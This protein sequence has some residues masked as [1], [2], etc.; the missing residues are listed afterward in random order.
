[1]KRILILSILMLSNSGFSQEV[2]IEKLEQSKSH[3]QAQIKSLND[4]ISVIN[5]LISELKM[6][7]LQNKFNHSTLTTKVRKGANLKDSPTPL[8]NIV[9]DL[10][11]NE[12]V[13]IK[14]L[15]GDYLGVCAKNKCGYLSIMWVERNEEIDQF[16]LAKEAEQRKLEELQAEQKLKE[17]KAEWEKIEKKYIQK[18]GKATYDK[19]KKGYYWIGMTEE[20][21][22]ISLGMPNDVNRT[23]GIWGVH[24]Q[25]I[26][27]NVYLY[28][29]NGKL[30]SYQ[31]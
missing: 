22:T 28:F 3:I 7:E 8:G 9:A 1:M 5:N 10:E 19:L 12:D 20:M 15:K 13:G 2:N 29:E 25:W 11:E 26:Y 18:Y 30:S 21:A 14:D 24:E 17:Q 23:V 27:D 4:S 16:I 6:K 31:N